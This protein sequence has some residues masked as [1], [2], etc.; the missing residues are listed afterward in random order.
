MNRLVSKVFGRLFIGAASLTLVVSSRA[1]ITSGFIVYLAM[2]Q[3]NGYVAYDS[4]A[5]AHNAVLTNFPDDSFGWVSGE[6]NGA[7][8]F[9]SN[10]N[11]ERAVIS[12]GAGLL[13]LCTN[14]GSALSLAVW[15]NAKSSGQPNGAGIV[16]KGYG[17]GGEKFC[18]D[19]FGGY[20]FY[21]RNA[22]GTSILVGPVGLAD[23]NWHHLVGIY[24]GVN[25]NNGLQLYLD[26]QLAGS[27][28][29]PASLLAT[30]HDIS[31]G[32]REDTSTSGY[33]LS[34]YG[35]EDEVRLYNRALSAADVQQLYLASIP[36]VAAVSDYAPPAGQFSLTNGWQLQSLSNITDSGTVISD[37]NYQP[38]GWYP[39]TVPGTVLTTLVNAGVYPEPLYGTNNYHI[40]DSLCRTS[41]WYRTAFVIPPTYSSNRLWLNF[42]GVNYTASVWLNGSCLGLIQ[43]AFARGKFDITPYANLGGTNVVAVLVN[44]E[45]NPGTA[46]QKTIASGTGSNGGATATDGPTFLCTVGWDWIPTIRDRATGIWQDVSVSGAGPV[47]IQNPY[48]TT[49]LPLPAT[50][51]ASVN[52]QVTLSNTTSS[53][54]SGTLTGTIGTIIFSQTVSLNPL[55]AIILAFNPTSTPSLLITNPLLWWPNGYGPQNL[56]TLQLAFTASNVLS[57]TQSLNFGIRQIAYTQPGSTNLGFVVNGV[58]VVAKGGDWGMDEAMKR[59]P[60]AR[61]DAQVHMHQQANYTIIRNWV[62]Q[63]TSE[64]FYDACDKY[65]LLV[66]DEFFQPNPGDG[67]NV[68]NA[69]LYLANVQEKLLRFRN[70]PCI[71][72]WCGRNEGNPAPAAVAQGNSNLVATLDPGRFY[73]PSSSAGMGVKSSGPYYWREPCYF[74]LVDAA[75]KTEIGSVSIPTLEAVEGMMPSNDWQVINDDWAEHDLCSGAQRGNL[76][77][78]IIAN[79]YGAFANLADFVR[80][81]QLANYEAFRA[82][83]EGRFARLFRPVTGVITW[84]SNPAQPSFVWQIYSWDLEPNASLFAARKACEPVHIMMNQTNWH[85][86]V[87]NNEPQSPGPLSARIRE[88]NL[89]GSLQ[90]AVTNTLTAPGSAVT[91]L[92]LM[93]FP[94]SLS[95]VHFVKLELY[96]SANHLLSDNF[97]WRET[98]QDNFQALNTLSNAAVNIQ[99][100]WQIAGSN[101]LINVTL[102]NQAPVVALMTHLQLRQATSGSRVLPVFYSDNYLSLLPGETKS[103]TIQAGT[104]SLNGDSPL[105][106]VDGWNVTANAVAGSD[107]TVAVIPN[108]AAMAT[109]GTP[110]SA[111]NILRINAG[112]SVGCIPLGGSGWGADLD[113][114]GGSATT[115]LT[116]INTSAL[117]AAPSWVYE[118]ERW[119][120]MTYTIPVNQPGLYLVRLHFAEVKFGPGGRQFNLAINGRQVLTNFDIAAAGGQCAAVV[121]DFAAR[122]DSNTNI[123]LAF[124]AGA[125]DQPKVS[126]IEVASPAL[127]LNLSPAS[128]NR[129]AL[130]WPAWPNYNLNLYTTTNL[131]PPVAW[132]PATNNVLLDNGTNIAHVSTGTGS[133]F[134]LLQ[135]P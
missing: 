134:F 42:D 46:H 106:A 108:L 98:A 51:P 88:F 29:A 58:N 84:M 133:E 32:S 62:G 69:P 75:F 33:T 82:M 10:T 72:L 86:M 40:P 43:G 128:G 6:T 55:S 112:G 21:V 19:Y 48:V 123:V 35:M 1:D 135:G 61:L 79:R 41:Y 104:N 52:V 68:T 57:D 109:H 14:T 18:L 71:A 16:A 90:Y 103:I 125:A 83:Y 23:G 70:H 102:S 24:N 17:H 122:P 15:V 99:A 121:R 96:D 5:N 76:Y 12:D 13:D 22:A 95:A 31:L 129:F 93:T 59:I 118:T 132:S 87:I 49:S 107:D 36:P 67:P 80:K 64:A 8:N 105:L 56:Y 2:D 27:T 28:N 11:N 101:V 126:G 65:G 54:Q 26:G 97:Y 63:S 120:A 111:T 127:V 100:T 92:G 77:P 45:P 37:T 9:N 50:N 110:L 114:S 44:P 39:A 89:D 74:Y 20:R 73:Q 25:T 116:N 119:G 113:Y 130:S 4:T 81:G 66:W 117:N 78:G 30:T 91:D 94:A 3:T 34:L 85:A 124:T 7:L 115:T 47:L 53:A 38:A 60:A 131:T